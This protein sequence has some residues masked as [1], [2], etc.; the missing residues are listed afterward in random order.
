[1]YK[2]GPVFEM[3]SLGLQG[4]RVSKFITVSKTLMITIGV[5]G[6]KLELL[7][8]YDCNETVPAIFSA[9]VNYPQFPRS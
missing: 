3:P 1:M 2:G 5:R 4:R 8:F 6:K 7:P 9:E